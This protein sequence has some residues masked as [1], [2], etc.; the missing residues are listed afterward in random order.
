MTERKGKSNDSINFTSEV[1]K[2]QTL[3]D[4]GIR[5]SLDLSETSIYEMARLAECRARGSLLDII[6]Q[7]IFTDGDGKEN[8]YG[9]R[10]K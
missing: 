9:G 10:L 2:V 8:E 7:P 5:L 4:G 3:A 1:F 6:A